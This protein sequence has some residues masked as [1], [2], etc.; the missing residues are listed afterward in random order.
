MEHKI[1]NPVVVRE[2][3]YSLLKPYVERMPDKSNKMSLAYE[4]GRAVIVKKDAFPAHAVRINSRVAVLDLDTDRVLEFT[5]V[6]PEYADMRSNKVSILTPM[7][8]ALIGFRKAEEVEWKVPA[9]LKRF[10]I[11]EVINA[12]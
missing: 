3:D 1:Q 9:G 7:G 8:A 5:L 2:D 6:M 12:A 4:L 10:R 11:L